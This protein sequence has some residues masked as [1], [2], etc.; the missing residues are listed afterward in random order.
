MNHSVPLE[1]QG[2]KCKGSLMWLRPYS[3]EEVICT[4]GKR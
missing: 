4:Y 1:A 3:T 2:R